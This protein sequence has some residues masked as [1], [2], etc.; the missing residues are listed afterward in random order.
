[1]KLSL[2][3]W[4]IVIAYVGI[5]FLIDA[6]GGVLGLIMADN[7]GPVFFGAIFIQIVILIFGRK[8]S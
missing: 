7:F 1:M 2:Y 3:L 6:N 8:K 4:G 5:G